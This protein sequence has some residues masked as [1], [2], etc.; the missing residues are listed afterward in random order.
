MASLNKTRRIWLMLQMTSKSKSNLMRVITA[1]D[2]DFSGDTDLLCMTYLWNSSSNVL[3]QVISLALIHTLILS[4]LFDGRTAQWFML[5][6]TLS[7]SL[8]FT[9]RCTGG[10]RYLRDPWGHL[11]DVS[12]NGGT[13]V[14][15]T[16]W[17]GVCSLAVFKKWCGIADQFE[18]LLF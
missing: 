15:L 11:W 16:F 6:C 9:H 4:A 5:L 13:K 17:D 2:K 12:L 14:L 8:R 7:R 18:Y 3:S 10:R 1:A